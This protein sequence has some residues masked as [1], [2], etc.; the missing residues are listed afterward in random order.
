MTLVPTD[1]FLDEAGLFEAASNASATAL[2]TSL[3]IR[4]IQ[5][6][7]NPPT[8]FY[9]NLQSGSFSA[10][11]QA[12]MLEAARDDFTIVQ[13]FL[14]MP[15]VYAGPVAHIRFQYLGSA[16]GDVV[17]GTSANDFINPLG[18]DDAVD[19]GPGD[20]VVD[21]GTGS[22][23]LTGGAGQ[24]V[25]FLDGRGGSTT[26]STIT[27]WESGEQLSLWGWR[28]GTSTLAWV[29][30]AGAEGYKGIT[31]HADLNADGIIDA[32]VTWSNRT[33]ADLPAASQFDDL[34]WFV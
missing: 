27:D 26:W 10:S 5:T 23:F 20:D 7:F 1:P 15:E 29:T 18:G 4:V 6:F 13:T 14:M 12:A 2:D 34:L 33:A 30:S 19:A 11:E 22:N 32:S 3:F 28:P 17:I 24:D 16:A 21:G 31:A 8:S 25:F 9:Q